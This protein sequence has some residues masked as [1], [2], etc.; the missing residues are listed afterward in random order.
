MSLR[1]SEAVGACFPPNDFDFVQ[2]K[3][4]YEEDNQSS[5]FGKQKTQERVSGEENAL[6]V[7]VDNMKSSKL[8]A[9]QRMEW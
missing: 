5:S 7:C 9:Q 8:C 4:L 6:C 3:K 1:E 2:I